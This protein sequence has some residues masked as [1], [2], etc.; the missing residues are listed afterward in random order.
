[1]GLNHVT[2][3]LLQRTENRSYWL[4][5]FQLPPNADDEDWLQPFREKVAR[6]LEIFGL[7]HLGCHSPIDY[8]KRPFVP[9]IQP[10]RFVDICHWQT[11][12]A[13]DFRDVFS[14]DFERHCRARAK[15]VA[16]PRDRDPYLIG[17]SF[18]D[19]PIFTDEEAAARGVQ[20]YGA[21]REATPTWP[22]VLRNLGED[23]AGKR[24]YVNTMRERYGND[25]QP[26]NAIYETH[27]D[28]FDALAQAEN[29]RPEVD[30]A[31]VEEREDNAHFLDMIIDRYYSVAVDAIRRY[32]RNHLILGDKLN[33]NTNT[34]DDAV[35]L[36]GQHMDLIFYQWYAT[37]EDQRE[38][39]DHWSN[40]TGKPLF[41]G[42]SSFSTPNPNMPNPLGPHY[43]D[44]EQ[45][46]TAF[47]DFAKNAFSRPDF[48]G[49][50]WC[51]WM[52]SWATVPRQMERQHSG[53]QDPFG[54]LH[55]PMVEAMSAFSR[56]MYD[57]ARG[58]ELDEGQE[59]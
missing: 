19:C 33:G 4:G 42:D 9:Y 28:T 59:A 14:R 50:S 51:G 54:R 36:A 46:A 25:I 1:F 21:P 5:E 2:L 23:A 24:T 40:I 57:I 43:P 55:E 10:I 12:A 20:V 44:Q 31:N 26:F 6:D 7:N 8:Y 3:N 16:A 45:R 39:L 15:E 47:L 11:P 13:D 53:L 30:L 32:D 48:V 38:R 34:P 29:W 35:A 58:V 17:Y 22:L 49:W 37:Y 56:G 52:D 41:N 27:F 18:T